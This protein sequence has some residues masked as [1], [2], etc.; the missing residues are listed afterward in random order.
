MIRGFGLKR[1]AIASTVAHDSHNIIVVGADDG[2][3]LAAARELA[4]IGGGL[5]VVE[6]GEVRA[7]VPLPIAGLMSDKPIREVDEA[8]ENVYKA[9]G[10]M[11]C[12][13][14]RPFATLSFMAL[15][16]IP[17]LKL[18][19]QGLFDSVNFKFASLFAD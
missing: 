6:R 8:L 5:T 19:D 14:E 9:A 11:G 12:Q 16:P 2:D 18:T 7:T 15:T 1:G 4:R 10:D 3:M 17:E 13:L